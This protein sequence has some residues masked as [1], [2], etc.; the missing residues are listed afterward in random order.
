MRLRMHRHLLIRG[1]AMAD[2][3]VH[4]LLDGQVILHVGAHLLI[5]PC[6]IVGSHSYRLGC[7][8]LLGLDLAQLSYLFFL[9]GHLQIGLSIC[10]TLRR[11]ILL[12]H[13]LSILWWLDNTS[14]WASQIWILYFLH[15]GYGLWIINIGLKV[16]V[17]FIL[18]FLFL[19]L[20]IESRLSSHLH[21]PF[22]L[23]L[24]L[25][26]QLGLLLLF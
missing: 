19:F 11:I 1:G 18:F 8:A 25:Y 4:W 14:S 26:Y 22:L 9:L 24:P 10:V 21:L 2:F 13:C 20:C 6:R 5:V 3:D 15:C 7:Q 12:L 16:D 23:T 17:R